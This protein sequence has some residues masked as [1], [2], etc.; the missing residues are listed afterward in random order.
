MFYLL[1]RILVAVITERLKRINT[2]STAT[3]DVKSVFVCLSVYKKKGDAL[4]CMAIENL[5]VMMESIRCSLGTQKLLS[6]EYTH[7]LSAT[8]QIRKYSFISNKESLSQW[9]D[10]N[11]Q[12]QHRFLK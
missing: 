3:F 9:Q 12:Y 7:N 8:V 5:Y 6:K 1:R 4:S 2:F 10:I 11:F